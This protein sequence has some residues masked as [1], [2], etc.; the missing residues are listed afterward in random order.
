LGAIRLSDLTQALGRIDRL[1]VKID[2]RPP[3]MTYSK[4]SRK[5]FLA[6]PAFLP[7]QWESAVALGWLEPE[8]TNDHSRGDPLLLDLEL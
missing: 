8:I 6:D 1:Q 2:V 5:L 7:P 3:V 4:A